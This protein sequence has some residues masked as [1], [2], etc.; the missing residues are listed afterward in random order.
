V[1]YVFNILASSVNQLGSILPTRLD[2]WR[3]DVVSYQR[4]FGGT[5]APQVRRDLKRQRLVMTEPTDG[6]YLA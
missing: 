5:K 4:P 6:G 2:R 3:P 1:I